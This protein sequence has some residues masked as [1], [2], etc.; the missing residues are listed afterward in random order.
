MKILKPHSLA[1]SL[2]LLGVSVPSYAQLMFSQYVDGSGNKKGMEILNPDNTTID[3]VDYE[4]HQFS[5]GSSTKTASFKL[6]GTLKSKQKFLVGRSELK[7]ALGDRVNQV[8]GLSFNGD[9]ALVLV[10]KGKAV[11]RFGRVGELPPG[12]GWG[13][14]KGNSF[15]RNKTSNDVTLIDASAAFDLTKEWNKWSDR[16]AF[17]EYLGAGGETTPPENDKFNCSSKDVPIADLHTAAQNQRYIIRGVLTAD[18]RYANG[19]SGF[20]LQTRDTKAKPN[21]SNAIFVYIPAASKVKG[22]VAGQEVVLSGRLSSFQNQLQIDQ[23]NQD[24]LT[25]DQ[26][27]NLVKPVDVTLPFSSLTEATGNTPKRYQGMLVKLPQTMTVSENYNYSRFGELALSLGRQY[28][29]TN[30]YPANSKEAIDLAKNNVLSKIILD[31]GYGTQNLTPWMP[32]PFNA[33]NTL[34]TGYELKNVE[35]ILEYRFNAWRIQP[36][37]N[38]Q[39]EVV[40]SANPRPAAIPVKAASQIR[41]AAF[42]VLNYDNGAEK[43]FPTDRGADSKSEFDRQHAKIVSAMKGIDADVF[44][45]MEIAN[46][47]YD[48]KSA[49]AYLTKSLGPDWKFVTPPGMKKLGTDVI[50]VAILY[51][52]KRVKPVNAAVVFDDATQKNRVTMAQSFEPLNGGKIFTVIPNHLKSKGSCDPAQGLDKDQ[53]DGQACWNETRVKHVNGLIQWMAKNPTKVE[54]PNFLLVGDMNSYAKEDPML[55]LEKA[56]FKVLLNDEKIGMGKKAYT[57]VFG[58]SSNKL[59]HGGAGNIDHAIAD[60][61]LYPWVKRSF[62]WAINAD[63][64]TG[65]DYNEEFKT[66]EQIKDFY[67]SDAFRSSDHDPVI[68]DLDF[69]PSKPPVDQGNGDSG[70]GSSSIWSVLGLMTL[71]AGAMFRRRNK[72]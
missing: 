5:N 61:D 34:R 59:G 8:A 37:A 52:S 70:G 66:P 69:N 20:Y 31:D 2:M 46:N 11:D 68:V 65:L 44:G 29:P 12:G 1:L 28:I 58:V 60:S 21:L 16:N 6:S 32:K 39:P 30:L 23:L 24:I 18:Y 27:S 22:G 43:G 64:P 26:G 51:N 36:V 54:K 41:V 4:I 55:A 62:T 49:I 35:G 67:S 72:Q 25:C 71:A 9:D 38:K 42:N 47:G 14:S 40:A 3:L 45:L 15:A 10:Y 19:M 48:D 17:D 63:E 57:Y 7:T 50:A 56:K 53:G 33:S 13:N